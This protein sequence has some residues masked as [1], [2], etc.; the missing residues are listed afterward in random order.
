MKI[1]KV[2]PIAESVF[3][4]GNADAGITSSE[5]TRLAESNKNLVDLIKERLKQPHYKTVDTVFG[6]NGKYDDEV[7]AGDKLSV[8]S[9]NELKIVAE[10]HRIN[11]ILR[12]GA[13]LKNE[14]IS[15]IEEMNN[16]ELGRLFGMEYPVFTG[17]VGRPLKKSVFLGRMTMDQF[18]ELK[19]VDDMFDHAGPELYKMISKYYEPAIAHEAVSAVYGKQIHQGGWLRTLMNSSEV[20]DKDIVSS[21][22]A[23]LIKRKLVLAYSK[24]EFEKLAKECDEKHTEEQKQRNRYVK[25][26]MDAARDLDRKYTEE[27][28][29][30][31]REYNIANQKYADQTA[32]YNGKI[33][34]LKTELIQEIADLKVKA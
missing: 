32:E 5:A 10:C 27:Y 21:S 30:A 9:F 15:K 34:V 12:R 1:S 14:Y 8:E 26:I 19:K 29:A 22:N 24:A 3:V 11:A 6:A 28:N 33:D 13:R 20:I 17:K 25:L 23:V 4:I 31:I 18:K 7:Y 2:F 16:S